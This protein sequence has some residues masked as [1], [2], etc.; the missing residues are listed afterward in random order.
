MSERESRGGA[1]HLEESTQRAKG[2][3]ALE[4][5]ITLW[6]VGLMGY[7]YYTKGYVDLLGQIWRLF[8]G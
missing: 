8:F 6:A 5:A 2:W 1:N 7:F 3:A 4:I